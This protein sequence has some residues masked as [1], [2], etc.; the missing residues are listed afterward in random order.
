[1]PPRNGAA[2]WRRARRRNAENA[3]RGAVVHPRLR[4]LRPSG[5]R[6]EDPVQPLDLL[7]KAHIIAKSH[8]SRLASMRVLYP[9]VHST[10][11]GP[12]WTTI[13]YF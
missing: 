4:P 3:E 2:E 6:R 9:G 12:S 13:G 5:L 1:M 10:C 8:Y 11:H 7:R